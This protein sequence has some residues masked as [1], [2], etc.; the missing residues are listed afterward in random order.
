MHTIEEWQLNYILDEFNSRY[1]DTMERY[2]TK[3]H[4]K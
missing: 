1:N 4:K 2:D 3:F